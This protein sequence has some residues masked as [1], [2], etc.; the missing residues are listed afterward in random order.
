MR[1]AI[2]VGKR[3]GRFRL[4]L[5]K[6][7]PVGQQAFRPTGNVLSDPEKRLRAVIEEMFAE[8]PPPG[9]P[10]E[11]TNQDLAAYNRQTL[12]HFVRYS[13]RIE[14]VLEE[15]FLQSAQ[16]AAREI[17]LIVSRG[18]AKIGKAET[19]PPSQ[20]IASWSLGD[21]LPRAQEWAKAEAGSLITNMTRDQ[22][23]TFR[24]V[25]DQS[26]T[27]GRTPSSTARP[28]IDALNQVEPSSTTAQAVRNLFGTNVNG[29]TARYEQ[30]VVNRATKLA[31]SLEDRGVSADKIIERVGKDT[32]K[33]ATKLRRSRANTIAR[34]EILRANNEG[35]LAGFQEATRQGVLSAEHARK[36]WT[37]SPMDVCPICVPL[38]GQLQPLDQPFTNGTMTPPAHPNCRCSF[39]IEPNVELYE[40]PQV[41][42][43]GT[44]E[45]PFRVGDIGNFTS[46]AEDYASRPLISGQPQGLPGE[47]LATPADYDAAQTVFNRSVA[48]EPG[49]TD[50]IIDRASRVGGE[51]TGLEYRIKEVDSLAG[52]I[53]RDRVGE[54]LTAVETASTI[55]DAVRYTVILP[56]SD[57]GRQAQNMIDELRASGKR[58]RVKNSWRRGSE[59]NGINCQVF[60]P[61]LDQWYEVQFHTEASFDIKQGIHEIYEERRKVTDPIVQKRLDMEMIAISGTQR[62]PVGAS[63]VKRR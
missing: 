46:T 15:Q 23:Q 50:D 8:M 18:F 27:L 60:D 61:D 31:S 4:P 55:K 38:D 56:P 37:V 11:P 39:D 20:L 3:T 36:S 30:A 12:A 19:P 49:I 43:T 41:L 62:F 26:Y 35:R 10:G 16:L 63:I 40:P 24:Q 17:A 48:I 34:T 22:Q 44:P 42:G 53:A 58:V 45:D 28:L 7:R 2:T 52:K 59:Y 51:L 32:E 21:D 33:Y 25:V 57:Y 1:P 6:A 54:G 47:I 29:L 13:T 9:I 14:Q 5:S